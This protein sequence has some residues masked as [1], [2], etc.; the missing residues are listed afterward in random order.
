M[1]MGVLLQQEGSKLNL[2]KADAYFKRAIAADPKMHKRV[3]TMVRI[4]IK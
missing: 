2:E 1:M 4:Y 3:T